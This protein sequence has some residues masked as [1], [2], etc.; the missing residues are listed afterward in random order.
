ML[1]C[2]RVFIKAFGYEKITSVQKIRIKCA[3][4]KALPVPLLSPFRLTDILS[5]YN[6]VYIPRHHLNCIYKWTAYINAS[7][8]G[9]FARFLFLIHASNIICLLDCGIRS[10]ECV[11]SFE[12][13]RNQYCRLCAVSS[14]VCTWHCE[15]LWK[16][17]TMPFVCY[18]YC[19]GWLTVFFNT[20]R[21][22]MPLFVWGS[23]FTSV[24]NRYSVMESISRITKGMMVGRYLYTCN[25]CLCTFF[26]FVCIGFTNA[27]WKRR[28]NL[29]EFSCFTDLHTVES[30]I[31]WS[32]TSF[33]FGA[34]SWLASVS[35]TL[36]CM[37]CNLQLWQLSAVSFW[38]WLRRLYS[39]YFRVFNGILTAFDTQ[40]WYN[41]L[42]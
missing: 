41:N 12:W 28:W 34:E 8:D 30:Y 3:T 42:W 27:K 22:S 16:L 9:I 26:L 35:K 4:S 29:K 33:R 15:A 13:R 31:E 32:D 38:K 25:I 6:A 17:E 18:D 11:C 1:C 39:S 2:I 10:C 37:F 7:R 21:R 36:L 24:V 20:Y 5:I 40:K 14:Y 23:C 19:S